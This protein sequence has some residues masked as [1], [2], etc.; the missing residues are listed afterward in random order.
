MDYPPLLSYHQIDDLDKPTFPTPMRVHPTHRSE[1]FDQF[2][3]P[4]TPRRG[5]IL[6]KGW[7]YHAG[8]RWS[9]GGVGN[10]AVEPAPL[11]RGCLEWSRSS[12]RSTRSAPQRA[13]ATWFFARKTRDRPRGS[14]VRRGEPFVD[15]AHGMDVNPRAPRDAKISCLCE[16]KWL[17]RTQDRRD[18]VWPSDTSYT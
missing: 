17:Q 7:K 15:D 1:K 2:E 16:T 4:K 13:P 14:S 6:P 9:D 11:L 3:E 10:R 12:F 18:R 5:G 8:V